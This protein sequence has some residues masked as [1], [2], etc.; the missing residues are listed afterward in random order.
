M[1]PC[2]SGDY[3]AN[4]QPGEARGP[5]QQGLEDWMAQDPS[6]RFVETDIPNEAGYKTGTCRE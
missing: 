2:Q 3:L 4:E 5:V 6:A 1:H